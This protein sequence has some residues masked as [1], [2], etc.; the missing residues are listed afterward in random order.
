VLVELCGT[1]F[2]QTN[3]PQPINKSNESNGRGYLLFI[4]EI[5]LIRHD[6]CDCDFSHPKN[7]KFRVL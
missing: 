1:L 5:L 4:I 7:P 2:R 3:K 6:V